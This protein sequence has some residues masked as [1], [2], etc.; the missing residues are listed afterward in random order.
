[1]RSDLTLSCS[2]TGSPLTLHDYYRHIKCL[3]TPCQQIDGPSTH[4]PYHPADQKHHALETIALVELGRPPQCELA[5]RHTLKC[6]KPVQS[7]HQPLPNPHICFHSTSNVQ[8]RP[9]LPS[10]LQNPGTATCHRL[11]RVISNHISLPTENKNVFN[12]QQE[13]STFRSLSPN[14]SP[15]LTLRHI[16]ARPSIISSRLFSI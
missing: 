6:T 5:Q 7:H 16:G 9:P 14:R 3:S 10:H 4:A 13:A 15:R 1:M 11:L 2:S 8:Q 12:P